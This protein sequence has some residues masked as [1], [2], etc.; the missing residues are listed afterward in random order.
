MS[1]INTQSVSDALADYRYEP[2]KKASGSNDLGQNE[3]MKLMI[4]QM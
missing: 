4:A 3:F 2:I 1:E